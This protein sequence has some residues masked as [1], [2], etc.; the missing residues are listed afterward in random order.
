LSAQDL[1]V[2]ELAAGLVGQATALADLR[3]S[4]RR[5]HEAAARSA[6]RVHR[7]TR[8]SGSLSSAPTAS[9]VATMIITEAH[10][11]L[12]ADW[13]GVWLLDARNVLDAVATLGMSEA[14]RPTCQSFPV[15][16]ASN[17]LCLS[18]ANNEPLWLENWQAFARRFPLAEQRVRDTQPV[19]VAFACL[20][21]H[22]GDKTIGGMVLS[23]FKERPFD[24]DERAMM[25]LF[26]QHCAQGIERARLYDQALDAVQVREDFLSVAGHELRTPLSTLLLQTELHIES[27]DDS[28]AT[29]AR[30]APMQRTMRRLIKLAD[31][32]LDVARMRAGRLRIEPQPLEL[33]ALV[34]EVAAR[35]ALGLQWPEGDLAL[36]TDGPLE[37]T[38]DPMRLEQVVVNLVSNACKY[39]AGRPISVSVG[40]AEPGWA[41]L[42]VRDQGM[43]IAPDDQARIF[44]RFERAA[45]ARGI[46]GFG[47]GLWIVREIVTAHRG[48]ITVTSTP[49]QGAEF[50]VRLPLDA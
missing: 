22:I 25:G 8:V 15:S 32:V 41:V 48:T 36:A 42:R 37:G 20:P 30:F 49:G 18:V 11:A 7:L 40:R 21:L 47:L 35:T 50:C 10:E 12:E 46:S 1:L 33:C 38:W 31:D 27:S 13:S 34:R 16:D 29:R 3:A 28:P 9:E 24:D 45:A 19:Q 2:A 5:L 43:G 4:E 6:D 39:G 26:A 17:P 23:F 44:Q 14:M